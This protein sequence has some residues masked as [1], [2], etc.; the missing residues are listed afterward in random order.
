MFSHSINGLKIETMQHTLLL[1]VGYGKTGSSALQSW[2][3]NNASCLAEQGFSY[4][5][6]DK[7]SI[8]YRISSGNGG[9]L[10]GFLAGLSNAEQFKQ[11]Y[12]NHDLAN[13]IISS[14]ILS[15]S[16]DTISKLESFC[17]TN[18]IELKVLAYV[19]DLADWT[20]SAYVQGVKR[21]CSLMSYS[22][23]IVNM[24]AF[25]HISMAKMMNGR[26]SDITFVHYNTHK[27]DVVAPFAQW[28]NIRE[29]LLI[30][31]ANRKVNRTLTVDEIQVVQLFVSWRQSYFNDLDTFNISM[32]ISDWLVNDF[33][34][35][36]SEVA[37][38]EK[39]IEQLTGKFGQSLEAFNRSIGESNGFALS[40]A[41]VTL[42]PQMKEVSVSEEVIDV[43]LFELVLRYV[44][45]RPGV[46]DHLFRV[47]LL[48]EAYKL[49]PQLVER[50]LNEERW[51]VLRKIAPSLGA[52]AT[53]NPQ[54]VIGLKHLFES[55][56]YE[57]DS[58]DYLL[59]RDSALALENS[60]LDL[61][62]PLMEIASKGRPNGKLIKDKLKQ[63]KSRVNK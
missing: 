1:H 4:A 16:P 10:N 19:R 56:R 28:A 23:Y 43:H 20:Y 18:S 7:D 24:K 40:Y 32:L 38:T 13:T 52:L 47:I 9:P 50:L 27:A 22:D 54:Q 62:L 49:F 26:F 61:A 53:L 51:K 30:P 3:A 48:I 57:L 44:L 39:N 25:P 15:L 59:F 34:N 42:V 29:D 58:Q 46:C 33:P 41:D 14:E 31:L 17:K 21:H 5:I 11:H 63:Y 35:K 36:E 12:F 8:Q 45:S 60:N 6:K 2:L 37:I 55:P